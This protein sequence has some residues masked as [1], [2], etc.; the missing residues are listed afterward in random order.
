VLFS[1]ENSNITPWHIVAEGGNV[2]VL[3]KMWELAKE[4]QLKP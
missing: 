3:E 4:L 1:K 2:E